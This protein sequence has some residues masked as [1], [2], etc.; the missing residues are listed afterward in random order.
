MRIKQIN[1]SLSDEQ[2][3][4]LLEK[5]TE[6]PFSGAF[7]NHKESG[8]YVCANCGHELFASGT[9][10]D[11]PA[12]NTGWPSFSDVASNSAVQISEDNS[13]G[14]KRLEVTCSNC[15]GHLGHLFD[16]GPADAGNKH[17]CINSCSLEF[18]KTK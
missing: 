3:R 10:F 9:K 15:S 13:F 2:K 16:D 12:P 1:P 8:T 7:L 18:K 14:M 5:A 4:V 6:A 11:A 17:Y